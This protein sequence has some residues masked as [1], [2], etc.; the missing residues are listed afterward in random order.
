[1]I[2]EKSDRI[3]RQTAMGRAGGRPSNFDAEAYKE[4]NVAEPA[5]NRLKQR[6]GL[7]TGYDKHER[8][9][10]AGIVVASILIWLRRSTQGVGGD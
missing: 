8:D 1:M 10:R 7:A 6:R 3:A 4:P 9:Y 2:P 5:L